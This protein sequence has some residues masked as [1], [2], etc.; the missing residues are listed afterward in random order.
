MCTGAG[1]YVSSSQHYAGRQ[2][3]QPNNTYLSVYSSGYYYTGY[4]SYTRFS[5]Y[6]CSGS[7]SSNI[8][9]F[10]DP[11]GRTYTYNFNDIRVERYSSS[12]SYAGC[13]QM[14]GYDSYIYDSLSYNPGVYICNIQ[15]TSGRTQTVTFALY[16]YN[17]KSIIIVLHTLKLIYCIYVTARNT[18]SIYSF[19]HTQNSNSVLTLTC[20]TRTAPPTEITWQRNGLNLTIDDSTVQMTQRVTNRRYSYFV[21][22]LSITDDPDNVVGNYTVIVGNAFGERTSSNIY[23]EGK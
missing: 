19:Q 3:N 7:S 5:L 2:A 23:I 4:H 13:I 8:G 10:T 15:D 21:N 22:T 16:N 12:S 11:Y 14:Y 20:E 17:S 1:I 6:C 18:P 9:S